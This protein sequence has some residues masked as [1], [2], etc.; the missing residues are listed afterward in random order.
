M[1]TIDPLTSDIKPRSLSNG[2]PSLQESNK[3]LLELKPPACQRN[4]LL[5][6]PKINQRRSHPAPHL[7]RRGANIEPGC[8]GQ[9][10]C[11]IG[12]R[13]ALAEKLKQQI[14]RGADR[15]CRRVCVRHIE[16]G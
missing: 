3:L 5:C 11:L 14:D 4:V 7:P 10:L 8:F 9:R 15:P 13:G 1:I 2:K 6:R 16:L 12:T